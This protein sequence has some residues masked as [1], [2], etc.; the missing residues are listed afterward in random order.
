MYFVVCGERELSAIT[1][2]ISLAS[3]TVSEK[4][5]EGLAS[6]RELSQRR[7]ATLYGAGLALELEDDI[8]EG[9]EL[10]E[11]EEEEDEDEEDEDETETEN[12]NENEENHSTVELD[13]E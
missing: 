12:E 4:L 13:D 2:G 8:L 10:T 3:A 6:L 9:M 5:S 1:S 7:L 11:E